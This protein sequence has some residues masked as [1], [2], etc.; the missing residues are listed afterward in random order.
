MFESQSTMLIQLMVNKA[1]NYLIT[2]AGS[3][4]IL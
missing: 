3:L 2:T 1:G 4:P